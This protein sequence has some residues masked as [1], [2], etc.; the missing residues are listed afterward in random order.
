MREY[1]T[2]L[3][4]KHHNCVSVCARVLCCNWDVVGTRANLFSWWGEVQG[5]ACLHREQVGAPVLFERYWWL[6]PIHHST[7]TLSYYFNRKGWLALHNHLGYCWWKRSVLERV[8]WI[9][10]ELAWRSGSETVHTVGVS[11]PGKPLTSSHEKLQ[12]ILLITSL[13]TQFIPWRAGS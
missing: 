7:T 9:A 8:C 3:W 4:S 6:P 12:W 10:T 11:Q 2:S 1:W 13:K 5:N